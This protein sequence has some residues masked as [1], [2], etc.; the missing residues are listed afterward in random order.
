LSEPTIR[1]AGLEKSYGPV[2]ALRGID[3][4][5][6]AGETIAVLGPNGAGKSTLLRLLAGLTRPSAGRLEVGG[7]SDDRRRARS[8]IGLIGHETF[9]YPALTARENLIFAG[10]LYGLPDPE[11]RAD[12][13]L[14]EQKLEHAAHRPIKQFSRGMAQRVSIA[15]GLLHDPP[16]LLLDEPFTGLD[17]SAATQLSEKLRAIRDGGKTVVLVSHDLPRSAAIANKAI[18][19]VR[20]QVAHRSVLS[21]D[22]LPQLEHAYRQAVDPGTRGAHS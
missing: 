22:Q 13:L 12:R 15:R 19:L 21:S 5:V 16:I 18:V 7:A 3:F 1:V 14:A 2:P 17:H 9:L 20:G 4:D 11:A 10:N 6:A 8:R